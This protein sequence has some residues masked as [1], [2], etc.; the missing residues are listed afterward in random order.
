MS[1][2]N[3]EIKIGHLDDFIFRAEYYGKD[4]LGLKAETIHY[5]KETMN[6][7]SSYTSKLTGELVAMWG[8]GHSPFK[9]VQA[10]LRE[11]ALT[12]AK[13]VS[14]KLPLEIHRAALILAFPMIR[15]IM[16]IVS[17]YGTNIFTPD[18]VTAEI[19]GD[20]GSEVTT[21]EAVPKAL[22]T[23]FNLGMLH[24]VK[25][26]IYKA[27]CWPVFNAFGMLA[28]L[29]AAQ[30][31][32]NED[33]VDGNIVMH[34]IAMELDH[35]FAKCFADFDY[36]SIVGKELWETFKGSPTEYS[37]QFDGNKWTL[38]DEEFIYPCYKTSLS[39]IPKR[40]RLSATEAVDIKAEDQNEK[41]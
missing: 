21:S 28:T 6:K 36:E 5:Y 27:N 24:R 8:E 15:E 32:A 7:S 9:D 20:Y 19:K 25:R 1:N 13:N 17:D 16:R 3:T 31:I 29:T 14:C 37:L 22:L 41:N 34:G 18:M 38:S 30:A 10:A 12:Y 40:F 33:D 11:I 35:T 23:M 2:F 26:G 39:G 4:L